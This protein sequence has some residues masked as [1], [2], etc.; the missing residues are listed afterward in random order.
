MPFH[1]CVC[2]RNYAI[3]AS[4]ESRTIRL[5]SACFQFVLSSFVVA[6]QQQ[7]GH[8][9]PGAARTLLRHHATSAFRR[10]NGAFDTRT[11]DL[12]WVTSNS[13]TLGCH[14]ACKSQQG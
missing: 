1:P 10:F 9:Q 7:G 8:F 2:C 13:Q 3:R 11:L 6:A 12:L 4:S 14:C 5:L